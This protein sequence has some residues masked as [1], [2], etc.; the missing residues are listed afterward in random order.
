[1]MMTLFGRIA[2]NGFPGRLISSRRVANQ[3]G[4]GTPPSQDIAF[5]AGRAAFH[6]RPNQLFIRSWSM[7]D[8]MIRLVTSAATVTAAALVLAATAQG[9]ESRA[10]PKSLAAYARQA[11]SR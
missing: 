11:E 7:F 5:S 1:M 6:R 10:A 9:A 2:T 3:G 8:S 4:G